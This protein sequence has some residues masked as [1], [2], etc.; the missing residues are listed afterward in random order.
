VITN[1][2][3]NA[4]DALPRRNGRLVV[5]VRPASDARPAAK[6]WPSPLLTMVPAWTAKCSTP[7]PPFVTTKG[8]AGTGLGLWVS[9]GILDKHHTR[10]AV[11]SRRDC[12]TVFRLFVPI[13]ASAS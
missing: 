3:G 13:E 8:E 9:K 10:V 2:I 6:A 1:L 7:L 4:L 12:G 11:R 5:G